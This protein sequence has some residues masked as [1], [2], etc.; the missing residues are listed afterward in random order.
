MPVFNNVL[1]LKAAIESILSQTFIDFEFII[2]DDGSTD[3]SSD[4]LAEYVGRDPRIRLFRNEVNCGIVFSL[5]RGIKE[6]HGKYIARMDSD[7][8]SLPQRFEK[9][10]RII[11]ADPGTVVL[12]S[13]LQYIDA[14]GRDLG[15][16]RKA[17]SGQSLLSVCPLLHPTVVMRREALLRH[18]YLY[19]ETYRYSEDYFLWLQL[20]KVGKLRSCDEVLLHYRISKS[21][22]RIRHLKKMLWAT[23][24]VKLA[25]VVQLGIRPTIQDAGRFFAEAILL[26]LPASLVFWFYQKMTFGGKVQ[27]KP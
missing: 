10:L 23:L 20:S 25:G 3:G 26:V 12:G 18:S 24:R 19:Q 7:D 14:K 27:L 8:I 1:Y 21:A 6:S 22:T 11:E 15:I 5:N 17:S 9:Q 16:V 4:I 13:A 2:V